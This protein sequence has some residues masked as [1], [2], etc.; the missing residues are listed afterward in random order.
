MAFNLLKISSAFW[1][2]ISLLMQPIGAETIPQKANVEQKLSPYQSRIVNRLKRCPYGSQPD[3]L[4]KSEFFQVSNRKYIVQV[5][6]IF[7]AY[8]GGYEYY[9]L[10][11]NANQTQVKPLNL[12][13][14]AERRGRQVRIEDN[15][16]GGLPTYNSAKKELT[17]FAKSRGI[18]DC[19]TFGRYRFENDRFIAKELRVKAEC[20]GKYI[21]PEKY[22]KVYP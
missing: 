9:L 6:C 3:A 19:G 4:Q 18:G 8:Q 1:V 12:L 10:T 5:M 14:I 15:T 13:K 2:V 17:F 22:Q 20:D 16:L 7:G 21:D 11:E